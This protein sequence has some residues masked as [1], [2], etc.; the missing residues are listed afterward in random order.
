MKL[1]EKIK[2]IIMRHKDLINNEILLP[3]FIDTL[4]EGGIEC[5]DEMRAL[6]ERAGVDLKKVDF[7]RLR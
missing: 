1:K 3:V 4:V 6:I 2:A 7:T 5:F